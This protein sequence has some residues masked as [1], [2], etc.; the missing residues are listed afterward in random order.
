[1]SNGRHFYACPIPDHQESKPSFVVYTHGEY[2]NF[3]C[4]GCQRNWNII[5]LISFIEGISY[6]KAFE[7]L[8]GGIAITH[9]DETEFQIL[10][11]TKN[12]SLPFDNAFFLLDMS[13]VCYS[14]IKSVGFEKEEVETIDKFWSEIDKCLV[15]CDF[16][17]IEEMNKNLHKM[18]S[19]RYD[20]WQKRRSIL[21]EEKIKNEQ[22]HT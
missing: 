5:H 1:M 11:A 13:N 2:E 9:E 14:F 22:R 7:R 18:V 8:S 16:G 4:F 12:T 15:D 17:K 21:N 19:A 10:Q 3:H 6:K 20:K